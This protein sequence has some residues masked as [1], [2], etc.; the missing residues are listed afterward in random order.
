MPWCIRCLR[1]LPP[2]C[3]WGRRTNDGRMLSTCRPAASMLSSVILVLLATQL[4]SFVADDEIQVTPVPHA[5]LARFFP[6][7]NFGKVDRPEH[8]PPRVVIALTTIPSRIGGLSATLGSLLVQTMQPDAIVITVPYRFTREDADSGDYTIPCF[9]GGPNC[10]G[11][12]SLPTPPQHALAA[13]CWRRPCAFWARAGL[14]PASLHAMSGCAGCS[15]KGV[16][17]APDAGPSLPAVSVVRARDWGP[18]TKLLGALR[19]EEARKQ[20]AETLEAT[21]V[22]YLDDDHIYPPNLVEE[23][24]RCQAEHHPEPVACAAMLGS[25]GYRPVAGAAGSIPLGR[26][27]GGGG[28]EPGRL[29]ARPP[30]GQG[31]GRRRRARR[32]AARCLW[33]RRDRLGHGA[34]G[35]L[36]RRRRRVAW[37]PYPAFRPGDGERCEDRP[38]RPVQPGGGLRSGGRCRVLQRPTRAPAR[39][40]GGAWSRCASCAV[41]NRRPAPTVHAGAARRIEQVSVR[42]PGLGLRGLNGALEARRAE[43]RGT[44]PQCQ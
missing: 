11:D 8:S 25:Y 24:V 26:A 15:E 20:P 23:H 5:V 10:G 43:R 41:P 32:R 30:R 13:G 22:I 34:G 17:P 3:W 7:A 38:P 42:S 28:R 36:P 37:L 19:H 16:L 1:T 9:L 44:S 40:L 35:T 6:R 29:R 14:S 12:E 27:G 33:R 4:K 18:A 39:D 31:L 2:P 21:L